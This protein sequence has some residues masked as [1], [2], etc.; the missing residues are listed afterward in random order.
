MKKRAL[1][2][3][4]DG[5]IIAFDMALHRMGV[6]CR[7]GR[8]AVKIEYLGSGH[9]PS[10]SL[11]MGQICPCYDLS[12]RLD[13]ITPGPLTVR[14]SVDRKLT[15]YLTKLAIHARSVLP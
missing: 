8:E 14:R 11:V 1:S 12:A 3:A 10:P 2:R 5:P 15:D 9:N 4:T 6:K 13:D 7:P